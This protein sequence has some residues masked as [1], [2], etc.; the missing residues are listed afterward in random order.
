[1]KHENVLKQPQNIKSMYP[2]PLPLPLPL[3]YG[4]APA[5]PIIHIITYITPQ[6]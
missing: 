2:N 3:D 4:S 6:Y 1:M 5:D